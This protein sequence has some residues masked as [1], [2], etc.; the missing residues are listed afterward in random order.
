MPVEAWTKGVKKFEKEPP[1]PG[2]ALKKGM[3]KFEKEPSRFHSLLGG[4]C[5][6]WPFKA[7][8]RRFLETQIFC[9]KVG[10]IYTEMTSVTF[11][12]TLIFSVRSNFFFGAPPTTP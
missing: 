10:V 1:M 7:V 4:P 5:T 3:K 8:W 11:S 6:L 2:E 9:P 12:T